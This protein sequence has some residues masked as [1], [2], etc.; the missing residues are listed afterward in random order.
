MGLRGR[1]SQHHDLT[2]KRGTCKVGGVKKARVIRK[3]E[4]DPKGTDA[5]GGSFC[6]E[7]TGL[8]SKRE[9]KKGLGGDTLG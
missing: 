7:S 5:K 6:G 4:N 1:C 9:V 2:I 3:G 8:L